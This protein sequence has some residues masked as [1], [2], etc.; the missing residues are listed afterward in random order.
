MYNNKNN[1]RNWEYFIES[2]KS[3]DDIFESLENHSKTYNLLNLMVQGGEIL[4]KKDR[5]NIYLYIPWQIEK[6]EFKGTVIIKNGHIYIQGIFTLPSRTLISHIFFW[7]LVLGSFVYL[8]LVIPQISELIS[9]YTILWITMVVI[10]FIF[11]VWHLVLFR[12]KRYEN[13]IIDYLKRSLME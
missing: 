4:L 7:L 11:D 2:K 12:S 5:H 13:R 3:L 9:G 10:I 1:F 8:L 6:R